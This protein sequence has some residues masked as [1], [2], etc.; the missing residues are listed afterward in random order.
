MAQL[1]QYIPC[2]G[3][4]CEVTKRRTIRESFQ[5]I[6]C[7][8]LSFAT[9]SGIIPATLFQYI[10]CYGLS[11]GRRGIGRKKK[12]SIHPML[13]FIKRNTCH[14]PDGKGISIHP[15]LRFIKERKEK[16]EIT[17]LF[18]YIPCYGL[19]IKSCPL[20]FE[21]RNFNTSHVTVYLKG[22]GVVKK[23]DANFNTSHVTV[24]H[25]I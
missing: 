7:Y 9:L 14:Y 12:I 8:G 4:S 18:Q 13:R 1:F 23:Q 11:R 22:I 24:Y 16:D 3:L 21:I 10:P 15:M 17:R 20:S 5:Y 6:P 25:H 19:S 2:Y